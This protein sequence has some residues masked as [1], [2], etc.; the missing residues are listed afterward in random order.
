MFVHSY[1]ELAK[2]S[3]QL[4]LNTHLSQAT[5]QTYKD[6]NSNVTG[7]FFGCLRGFNKAYVPMANNHIFSQ[8]GPKN[9][10]SEDNFYVNQ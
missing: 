9:S 6:K 5:S 4:S 10:Q 2:I 3:L 8:F 7:I 1:E